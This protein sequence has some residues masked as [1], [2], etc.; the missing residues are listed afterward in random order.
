VIV[1]LDAREI[2]E[3]ENADEVLA[4]WL[5]YAEP[6]DIITLHTGMCRTNLHV[7]NDCTCTPVAMKLGA[8]A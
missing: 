7:T 3:P 2:R 5:N 4:Y 8:R 6:D 1:V